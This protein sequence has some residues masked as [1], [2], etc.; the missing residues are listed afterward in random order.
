M[1]KI[2]SYKRLVDVLLAASMNGCD[3]GISTEPGGLHAGYMLLIIEF[4]NGPSKDYLVNINLLPAMEAIFASPIENRAPGFCNPLRMTAT[5]QQ[6][7][8]RLKNS[9]VPQP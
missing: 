2:N 1:E 4:A 9:S 7:L 3:A 6:E 5:V 8:K